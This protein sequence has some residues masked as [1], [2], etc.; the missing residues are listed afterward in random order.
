MDPT[1]NICETA[2]IA[3]PEDEVDRTI[4]TPRVRDL[5]PP[6]GSVVI[7][8]EL[9]SVFCS[10]CQRWIDCHAGIAP[11]MALERHRSLAH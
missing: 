7:A 1:T 3:R 5:M 6:D 10:P 4:L 2:V 8:G 9:V 11:D